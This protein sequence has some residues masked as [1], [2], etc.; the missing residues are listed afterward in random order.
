MGA[1]R[2]HRI[3]LGLIAGALWW[4][5]QNPGTH[6]QLDLT[7]RRMRLT[8]LGLSGRQ[9]REISFDDL[10][11]V[12]VEQSTDDE[13][14][15]I[16]RPTVRLQSGETVTLSEQWSHDEAGVERGVALVT[17]ACGVGRPTENLERS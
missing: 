12:E 11:S 14:G 6:V 9:L 15:S 2:Q 17:E 13:G 5:G 8:R 3:G 1:A 16:W 7:R 4:L 10:A